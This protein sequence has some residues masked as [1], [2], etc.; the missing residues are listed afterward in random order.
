[1]TES[2]K[3]KDAAD[4]RLRGAFRVTAADVVIIALAVIIAVG[5][6]AYLFG[7]IS[8]GET[9]EITFVLRVESVREEFTDR[10]SVGDGVYRA[11]D[12]EYIGTVSAYEIQNSSASEPDKSDLYVTITATAEVGDDGICVISGTKILSGSDYRYELRTTD[13]YFEGGIVSITK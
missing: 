11:S 3:K 8:V 1:M 7:G 13:F 10:I 2:A 9:E 12:G 5:L 4:G 6:Y